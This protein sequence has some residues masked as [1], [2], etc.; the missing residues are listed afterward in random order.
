[1]SPVLASPVASSLAQEAGLKG[2]ERVL[3]IQTPSGEL[4]AIDS[5]EALRW[6]LTRFAIQKDDVDMEVLAA[7]DSTRQMTIRLPLSGL[8]LSA[9]AAD[10]LSLIGIAGPWTDPVLGDIVENSAAQRAQLR[11]GDLVLKVDDVPVVDGQQLRSLI[12]QA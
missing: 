3:S 12:R 5:L 10:P 1:M 7:A 4:V 2:G 6:H 11:K 8:D 9:G